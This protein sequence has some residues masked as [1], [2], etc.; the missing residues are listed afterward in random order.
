[1]RLFD[2]GPRSDASPALHGEDSYTFLNP[3]DGVVWER[4][5][6]VLELWFDS[7]PPEARADLR[8]RFRKKLPGQHWSAWWELYVHHLLGRMGYEA[9]PHPTLPDTSDQPDFLA[10]EEARELLVEAAVVF[11]GIQ[12]E[13]R[14]GTREGW[15]L[16]IVNRGSCAN[17]YL[18]IEFAALGTGPPK[19]DAVLRP[20][21]AWLATLDPDEVIA[22]HERSGGFPT[23]T[24]TIDDWRLAFEAYPVSPEHRHKEPGRLVGA[25]P[26]VGGFVNDVEQLRATVKKKRGR[27]GSTRPLVLTIN[28][29]SSFMGTDD[30]AKALY[31]STALEYT[32]GRRGEE[33]WVRLRDGAL[34][35]ERGPSVPRLRRARGRATTPLE[36]RDR[37]AHALA[38]PVGRQAFR[39]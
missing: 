26:A 34:M 25:G 20:L 39:T 13:T 18:G 28:C 4:I 38:Q 11:S 9:E 7:Y 16:D 2:E 30:I 31:G 36:R 6:Q 32:M 14:D 5:R 12:D 8:G 37:R 15:I 21:L 1:M 27:Y 23:K 17:F 19:R 3:A 33:R 35:T 10:R 24:L 22:A 29:A